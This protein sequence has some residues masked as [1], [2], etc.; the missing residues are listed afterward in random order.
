MH[1]ETIFKKISNICIGNNNIWA[2]NIQLINLMFC[3]MIL[4]HF[5]LFGEVSIP[6]KKEYK[7]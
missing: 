4:F 6:L 1:Y 5:A 7:N 2:I 3:Q